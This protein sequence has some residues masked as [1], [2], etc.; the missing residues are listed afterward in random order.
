MRNDLMRRPEDYYATAS[1]RYKAETT[2]EANAA[3][4]GA[5]DPKGFTWVVVGDAAK[6]KPQLEKLGMP[7]EVVE[8]P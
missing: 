5:L 6:L 2:A 3:M 8:A 4:R 7:V 1:G